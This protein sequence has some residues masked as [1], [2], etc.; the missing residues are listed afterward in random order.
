MLHMPDR[1]YPK[2]KVGLRLTF[3][4]LCKAAAVGGYFIPTNY[5]RDHF[6]HMQRCDYA[7]TLTKDYARIGLRQGLHQAFDLEFPQPFAD[8][9]AYSAADNI[10][11]LPVR[12]W[13]EW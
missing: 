2:F 9:I 10:L 13:K 8:D 3:D 4:E 12:E 7:A 5:Y 6:R 11:R 1:D